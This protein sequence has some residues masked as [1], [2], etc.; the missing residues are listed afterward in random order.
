MTA[1]AYGLAVSRVTPS[2]H[3]HA[4]AP[5]MIVSPNWAPKM[6]TMAAKAQTTPTMYRAMTRIGLMLVSLA[7]GWVSVNG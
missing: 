7:G 4:T 2:Q 5:K 1:Q 6:A 3:A